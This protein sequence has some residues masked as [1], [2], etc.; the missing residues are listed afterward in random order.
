M[1]F[2]GSADLIIETEGA[3]MDKNLRRGRRQDTM[4]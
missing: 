1:D 4:D 2:F 3:F